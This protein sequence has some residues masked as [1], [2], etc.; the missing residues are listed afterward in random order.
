[1]R[2]DVGVEEQSIEIWYDL[3]LREVLGR[4]THCTYVH[5]V[6]QVELSI[7][8]LFDVL[9]LSD[10]FLFF[11]KVELDYHWIVWLLITV[12]VF[13]IPLTLLLTAVEDVSAVVIQNPD[14]VIL[15]VVH[16]I[17]SLLYL[18]CH[19]FVLRW[20][21]WYLAFATLLTFIKKVLSILLESRFT[22]GNCLKDMGWDLLQ[23][24]YRV[25]TLFQ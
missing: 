22:V 8:K 16:L 9:K 24:I 11:L 6:L 3:E 13:Q 19:S 17:L 18:E 23:K 12:S 10:I 20:V 7:V 2:L 15:H 5:P 21:F 25:C 4:T 14:V 1:M